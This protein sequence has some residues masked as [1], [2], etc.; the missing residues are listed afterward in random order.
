[1]ATT[2]DTRSTS[3]P[4]ESRNAHFS[5]AASKVSEHQSIMAQVFRSRVDD[6][7]DLTFPDAPGDD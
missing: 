1:M 5:D 7:N 2:P 6:Q 3:A 4:G